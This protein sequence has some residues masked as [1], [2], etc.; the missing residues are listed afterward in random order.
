MEWFGR[1]GGLGGAVVERERGRAQ[2]K[3]MQVRE[4]IEVAEVREEEAVLRGGETIPFDECV[5]CT[6]AAAPSWLPATGLPLGTRHPHNAAVCWHQCLYSV[7]TKRL[8]WTV[9][10]LLEGSFS[11]TIRR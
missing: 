9:G 11:L 2:E 4:E 1:Y 3:G 5:W 8:V 10:R 7:A 6:G